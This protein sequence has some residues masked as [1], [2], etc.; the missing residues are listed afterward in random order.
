MQWYVQHLISVESYES[1][2]GDLD[3][4]AVAMGVRPCRGLP[5]ALPGASLGMGG[6]SGGAVR[7]EDAVHV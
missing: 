6:G 4:V 5:L 2:F 1:D 3:V 7:L